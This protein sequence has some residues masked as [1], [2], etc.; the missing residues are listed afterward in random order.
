MD[1]IVSQIHPE[2]GDRET[3]EQPL[4]AFVGHPVVILLGDPG[5]GKTHTFR[6][7][8]ATCGGR[9]VTARSF[10]T[11]PVRKTGELLF[12]DGLDERRGGRG[13]RDTIDALAAK[14]IDADPSG[15][16]VSC[17]VADWLDKSDLISLEPFVENKGGVTVILLARLTQRE[18]LL[19]LIDNDMPEAEAV[20]FLDEAQARGLAEFLDN[21]QNLLLLRSA[22]SSGTWPATRREMFEMAT[23]LMLHENNAER[24]RIGTGVFTGDELQLA[25]GGALAARLISDVEGIGLADQ[26][27]DEAVPSYRTL[28]FFTPE[29]TL[30]AL[31]RRVFGVG[32]VPES[33]DYIHRTTAEYL[34]AA[35]LANAIRA[36][37][38]IGRVR[39][40][41]GVDGHPTPELRGLHAWLPIHLPEFAEQFIDADPYGV[42]T[43]GDAGSLSRSH[44]VH[45]LRALEHLSSTDPWFRGGHYEAPTIGA[46]ARLDMVDEFQAILSSPDEGLGVRRIVLEAVVLGTPL[47]ALRGELSKLLRTGTR[48]YTERSYAL[49]AL[50]RF[51]DAGRDEIVGVCANE[52]GTDQSSLRIRADA[53][54]RL[55]G[56]PYGSSD[57][58]TLVTDTAES[59]D[60]I[61]GGMFYMLLARIS[62]A[63]LP[64]ILD[65][66]EAP[67]S[68]SGQGRRNNWEIASFF[69]RALIRVLEPS[70]EINGAQMRRW[71]QKRTILAPFSYMS[72]RDELRAAVRL[73]GD[74]LEQSL[75]DYLE[76][77]T[78]DEYRWLTLNR[79]RGAFFFEISPD[80]IID[81][82]IRSIST[83][84]G[85]RDIFFYEAALS[86]S[87]QASDPQTSFERV[88]NFADDHP[89]FTETR[90]NNVISRISESLLERR[91]IA[92]ERQIELD[93]DANVLRQAIERDSATIASGA[94]VRGLAWGA[95]VYLGLFEDVDHTASPENRFAPLIGENLSSVI[96]DG[97]V[98]SLPTLDPPSLR[99]VAQLGANNRHSEVWYIF[100][101]GI[102]EVYRRTGSLS[103]VPD[104]TLLAMLAF[105]LIYPIHDVAGASASWVQHPWKL[106]LMAKR[107]DVVRNAYETIARAKISAARDHID[108][109]R[110]LLTE[111]A[112]IEWRQ[113][114][115]LGLLSDFPNIQKFIL[116]ELL[117]SA[118][119]LP[120]ART[121]LLAVADRVL[122]EAVLDAPQRDLWLVVAWQLSPERYRDTLLTSAQQRS[123]IVFDLRDFTGFSRYATD[124][125]PPSVSQLEYLIDLAGSLCP[126]ASHP[127]RGWSGNRNAWDATEYVRNLITRLSASSA[128][129]ATD[130]LSRLTGS[131]TLM[132]YRPDLL[133]ALANQRARR[134]EAEY[135][136][137]NW[138]RTLNALNNKQPAT[139][140]D[141]HALL[142]DQLNDL[143]DR[144]RTENTDIFK[145]F[146]NLD[147]YGRL[148]SPRPEEACRDDLITL[149]RPRLAPLG[150][151]VEPEGHMA[152]DRR[153]DILAVI[154]GKK[155]P[156]EI[157][158]DYH[159][160]LWEAPEAQLE[161][162]YA[163]D[164]EAL[165]FGIYLVF[166]FGDRRPTAVPLPPGGGPRPTTAAELEIALRA[167]VPVERRF[168]TAVKVIDVT[169][170]G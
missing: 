78:A 16:W 7:L 109:L 63:D 40:L 165:G 157:K 43:Y 115:V 126:L 25:A 131:D 143:R 17:R 61:T 134:R 105:D 23:Q 4:S 6:E 5:A 33:V 135:D 58:V 160:A 48:P 72:N 21:P 163:H 76:S 153:V 145:M 91:A 100:I 30:A 20:E 28:P 94:N 125:T 161:R 39:A 101:A 2:K 73:R 3:R 96:L 38:P 46:L 50:F 120:D 129:S 151:S 146:W 45:L 80:Q 97:L 162:F 119:K 98:A 26:E 86:L 147:Q 66:I 95:K 85:A 49:T 71:L 164:P 111:N 112:F 83:G 22:V 148:V 41:I 104:E 124:E 42:L 9:Y 60:E 57:V 15:V 82:M 34:G 140:A 52:L 67:A 158:R 139:V 37:L 116:K 103:G 159:D 170:P 107:P 79:F 122:A 141:L 64:T 121:D 12:I 108:G 55:Y 123:S 166:W 65:A 36:G 53:I 11:V 118:L 69:D 137:P 92:G 31:S 54:G 90:T 13:D 35:W 114:I 117:A 99:E 24:A 32:P 110:E 14:L 149:L 1:R 47:P 8:A 113:D 156:C 44:C 127:Q 77:A 51:G 136:R 18:R 93:D 81:G 106:E 133:H 68:L 56:N 29:K 169:R 89:Y 59:E 84:I 75:A 167:A 62:V 27:R 74:L 87:Y 132:N 19:V 130:A 128:P 152:A 70:N 102:S 150:I 142:A 144:I 168:R 88:Y 154:S 155:I 10:L 138:A